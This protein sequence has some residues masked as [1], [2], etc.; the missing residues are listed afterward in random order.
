MTGYSTRGGDTSYGTLACLA[1][2]AL[3]AEP[4]HENPRDGPQHTGHG[5]NGEAIPQTPKG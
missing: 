1:W 5:D 2:V 4:E 3:N